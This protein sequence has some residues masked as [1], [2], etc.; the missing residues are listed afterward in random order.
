M[1]RKI[2]TDKKLIKVLT[3]RSDSYLVVEYSLRFN[4]AWFKTETMIKRKA[5]A[6]SR[7]IDLYFNIINLYS[8]FLFMI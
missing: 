4:R 1:V 7:V 6:L 2:I 5:I 3:N 8:F